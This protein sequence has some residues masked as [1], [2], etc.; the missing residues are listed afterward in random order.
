[1]DCVSTGGLCFH[2]VDCVSTRLTMSPQGGLCPQEVDVSPQDGL[3]LHKVDYV[4]TRWTVIDHRLK[5]FL[6]EI[7]RVIKIIDHVNVCFQN[8][9]QYI[10][11]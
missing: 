6:N 5:M 9:S 3:C 8:K 10:D 7:Y 1:M 11:R 2:K 4:S